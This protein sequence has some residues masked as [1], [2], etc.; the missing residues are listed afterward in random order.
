M[1]D[2]LFVSDV[3]YGAWNP[4]IGEVPGDFKIIDPLEFEEN[5]SDPNWSI[6]IKFKV[7]NLSNLPSLTSDD[8]IVV[9]TYSELNNNKLRFEGMQATQIKPQNTIKHNYSVVITNNLS[10]NN[11]KRFYIKILFIERV[12]ERSYVVDHSVYMTKDTNDE[13]AKLTFPIN[14]MK[15]GY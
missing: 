2:K 13:L 3:S 1:N 8:G 4:E 9:L 15:R 7:N 14:L 12:F 6:F 5:L 10:I 11:I